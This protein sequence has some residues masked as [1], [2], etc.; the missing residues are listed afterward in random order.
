MTVGR[1]TPIA[2]FVFKRPDHT[3]RTLESLSRNPQYRDLP[4]FVF[5]DGAR[6]DNEMAS[7]EATREVVR[8]FDHPAMTVIER[9]ENWGLA[10]SVIAGVGDLCSKFGR[11]IVLEDDLILSPGFLSFM[12]AALDRY[13]NEPQVMQIAGYAFPVDGFRPSDSVLFLPFISSWGWATWERAWNQFDA[14]ATGW[15]TLLTDWPLSRRFDIDGVYPYSSML[16]SQMRGEIDSWAIRWN[17]S[18][19]KSNGMVV[20]PPVSL[21]TNIGFDGSG[22][23]RS[24]NVN[25]DAQEL[26]PGGEAMLDPPPIRFSSADPRYQRVRTAVRRMQGKPLKQFAKAL[27][28][29][30][31]RIRLSLTH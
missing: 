25:F 2:L 21:V 4:L 29:L 5:C 6:R 13:E 28:W 8:N 19:F 23:H 10:R 18:V 15:E 1:Q 27:R 22:T 11:A 17:W 9:Q 7:V 20:Y 16:V 26:A 31:I 14:R 24:E 3:L 30:Y 12:L